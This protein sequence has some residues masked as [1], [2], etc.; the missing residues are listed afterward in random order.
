MC[1]QLKYIHSHNI[2]C[3]WIRKRDHNIWKKLLI[4]QA[5]LSIYS[6]N[7]IRN[8]NKK[9]FIFNLNTKLI[10]ARFLLCRNKNRNI[11]RIL[12]RYHWLSNKNKLNLYRLQIRLGFWS[13]SYNRKVIRTSSCTKNQE[14]TQVKTRNWLK[15]CKSR[16]KKI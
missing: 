5:S 16:R 13:K 1:E 12:M 7:K 8:L 10:Q 11:R 15:I 3:K 4:R 2:F 6:L 14:S 9:I